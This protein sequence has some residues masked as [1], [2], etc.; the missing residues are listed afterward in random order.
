MQNKFYK[1][2]ANKVYKETQ[3]KDK[4]LQKAYDVDFDNHEK[5]LEQY[6]ENENDILKQ[7]DILYNTKLPSDK[8]VDPFKYNEILNNDPLTMLELETKL[9]SN[10][11]DCNND[12]DSILLN[13]YTSLKQLDII[14]QI[15]INN[16]IN[17]EKQGSQD[18]IPVSNKDHFSKGADLYYFIKRFKQYS[19]RCNEKFTKDEEKEIK[20]YINK[21]KLNISFSKDIHNIN[22]IIAKDTYFTS[23]KHPWGIIHVLFLAELYTEN[24]QKYKKVSSNYNI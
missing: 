17:Q 6:K 24:S 13:T 1:K 11:V 9:K 23:V 7:N 5:K 4:L 2:M 12:F 10:I 20:S 19:E 3:T 18:D 15:N 22:D 8:K 21:D 16:N 14:H